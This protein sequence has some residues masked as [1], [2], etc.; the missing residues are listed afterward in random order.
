MIL[1][2]DLYSYVLFRGFKSIQFQIFWGT[3]Q[4][5]VLSP[6]MFLCFIN[7]LFDELCASKLALIVNGINLTCPSVWRVERVIILFCYFICNSSIYILVFDIFVSFT[8]LILSF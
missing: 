8:I 5:G 3:R 4:E 1:Y 2:T 6:Y 7:D